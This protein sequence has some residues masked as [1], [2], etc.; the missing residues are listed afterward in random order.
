[1]I[2]ARKQAW[3]SLPH[4]ATK[5]T[6]L[7]APCS[8]KF[9][10]EN[11]TYRLEYVQHQQC[12]PEEHC[13]GSDRPYHPLNRSWDP[14]L[15]WHRSWQLTDHCMPQIN[16][17]FETVQ[18]RLETLEITN[19]PIDHAI[20]DWISQ[21]RISIYSRILDELG[22]LR[23]NVQIRLKCKIPTKW[24]GRGIR[25]S[26]RRIHRK[27][28]ILD[29]DILIRVTPSAETTFWI[30]VFEE[31][32]SINIGCICT[33]FVICQERQ[34]LCDSP[35]DQSQ[36]GL[37]PWNPHLVLSA[38]SNECTNQRCQGNEY[39]LWYIFSC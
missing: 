20:N 36:Y 33:V 32:W 8:K 7:E 21:R 19:E 2:S 31:G 26:E 16:W 28:S 24:M 4:G 22:A 6:G 37:L 25:E 29:F 17:S 39:P 30:R 38:L 35:F 34:T 5:T 18:T 23:S 13:R 10:R 1:M 3:V 27:P 15:P 14:S 11:L 9:Y 12:N